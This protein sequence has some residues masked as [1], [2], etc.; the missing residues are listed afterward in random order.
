M[1]RET[2]EA[3]ELVAMYQYGLGNGRDALAGEQLTHEHFA[4]HKAGLTG[5]D[6]ATEFF[7]ITP[8]QAAGY[9]REIGGVPVAV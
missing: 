5:F 6:G 4:E 1:R 8:E 2:R 7:R 9:I 3:I